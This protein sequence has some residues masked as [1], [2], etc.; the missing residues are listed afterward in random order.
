MC[1]CSP[2]GSYVG[3]AQ[4]FLADSG[5]PA[6]SGSVT[7]GVT[8]RIAA[9]PLLEEVSVSPAYSWKITL[10]FLLSALLTSLTACRASAPTDAPAPAA[11]APATMKAVRLHAYTGLDALR[12]EEDVPR[13]RPGPGELLIRV[14]AAAVNPVDVA[15]A[16][17]K[18][19]DEIHT[20]LPLIMG[21]DMSGVVD[22]VGEGVTSFKR[23]DAVISYLDMGRHGAF[24]E[25][26]V[27][28][29]KDV[30]LKP[31]SVDHVHAAAIPLTGVTAWKSLVETA[32]VSQ[33]QSVLIHGASGGVGTMAVQIAKA[34]GARVIATASARNLD[35]LRSLG[36]DEVIDYEAT[37]FEDV[38]K[39]IDVVL[40]AVGKDTQDRSW[41]VLKKG[42]ILVSIVRK[43][44][45]E[46]AQEFGVRAA[47]VSADPDAAQLLEVARLV[48]AGRIRPTVSEVFELK[49]A[50]RAL[51]QI[52]TRHTRG[53][54]VLRI[55]N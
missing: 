53:K 7:S 25:Y 16:K 51:D 9:L 19:A 29:E 14:H 24:A 28:R 12:Y 8:N 39:D 13:P 43:P 1:V 46:K 47:V 32:N 34:R 22:D 41:Q 2:L 40:D 30:V 27:A 33:G 42:G 3:G 17:G 20:S 31:K 37:R 11:P 18:M 10:L 49:D 21:Y 44:S 52:A 50:R 5:G 48:D 35:Y 4:L 38:A 26:V 36:A 55:T 54:L 15:V 23:G 6:R 45:Q